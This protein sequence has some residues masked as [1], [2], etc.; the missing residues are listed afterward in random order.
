DTDIDSR[1][2]RIATLD[3]ELTNPAIVEWRASSRA[4]AWVFAIAAVSDR[5]AMKKRT[6]LPGWQRRPLG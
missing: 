6:S 4:L 1:A 2:P 3:R 5:G